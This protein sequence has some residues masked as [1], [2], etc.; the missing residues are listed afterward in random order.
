MNKIDIRTV[1]AAALEL[2]S[3]GYVELGDFWNRIVLG[4]G[5]WRLYHHDAGGAG[6]FL[7]AR[8]VE[9]APGRCYLLPPGCNLETWCEGHPVQ[10]YLHFELTGLTWKLASL[11]HDLPSGFGAEEA[12][13]LRQLIA[14]GGGETEI[15][16][17]ALALAASALTMLPKAALAEHREDGRVASA[18]GYMNAHLGDELSLGKLARR[19]GL[20]ENA[21]L[22]IFRRD[23]GCAPYQYLLQQRYRYAAR[24]LREDVRSIEEICETVGI[25]DRF[26]FS[27][28]F[29]KMFG[30]APGAYRRH[31]GG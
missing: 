21:F 15:R 13:V 1:S 10:L 4:G 20:S 30:M 16:L 12:G 24:L 28:H 17:R 19:A 14:S 7:G 3:F 8:R 9:F 5:H 2:E 27:R 29:K 6:I 26:H 25:R 22:R 23:C 18:R 11:F 31:Y